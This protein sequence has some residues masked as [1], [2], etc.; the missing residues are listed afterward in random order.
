MPSDAQTDGSE[1]EPQPQPLEET[2]EAANPDL[3]PESEQQERNDSGGDKSSAGAASDGSSTSS[4]SE[5]RRRMRRRNPERY[6]T[7]RLKVKIPGTDLHG[8]LRIYTFETR[9]EIYAECPI[10]SHGLCVKSRTVNAGVRPGQGRPLGF[11][12]AWLRD[13]PSH[14]NALSHKASSALLTRE[15]RREARR[16]LEGL[17]H[18]EFFK[19]FER[20]RADDESSDE[21]SGFF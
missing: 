10:K 9:R 6:C 1:D 8:V 16:S 3:A 2:A 17:R 13:G 19:S 5:V 20:P 18:L 12:T 14:P 15:Q 7:E 11:L 21:P 4:S